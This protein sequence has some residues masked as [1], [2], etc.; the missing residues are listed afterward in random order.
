MGRG[1]GFVD[2]L[3]CKM[4]IYVVLKRTVTGLVPSVNVNRG[5]GP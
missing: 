1:L 5:D 2:E 3:T 4:Q